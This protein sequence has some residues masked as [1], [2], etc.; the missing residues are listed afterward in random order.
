M[1]KLKVGEE[2]S[3]KHIDELRREDRQARI[4]AELEEVEWLKNRFGFA[5]KAAIE[6]SRGTSHYAIR[7]A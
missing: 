3:Y 5:T 4:A 2:V 7:R 1:V 6:G